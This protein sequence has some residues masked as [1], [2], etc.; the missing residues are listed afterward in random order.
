MNFEVNKK[1]CSKCA[2][3]VKDCVCAVLEMGDDAFPKVREGKENSCV[4]CQHCFAICPTGAVSIFGKNPDKSLI[5]TEEVSSQ[6]LVALVKNRR[7][8]R[9]FER[10]TISKKKLNTILDALSWTPTGCNA[11]SLH[12]T[13]IDDIDVMDKFR[14]DVVSK[15]IT[16]IESKKIPK[17][18]SEG[19]KFAEPVLLAGVDLIFRTAPQIIFVSTP[20]NAPTGNNDCI[21][22]LS[23]FEM[24]A[25]SMKIGTTWCGYIV[26]IL[27]NIL[28]EMYK[29]LE[30]PEGNIIHGAMLFG[31][32]AVS[33]CRATQPTAISI[34]SV[35]SKATD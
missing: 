13:I 24:I 5:L 14:A 26:T 1:R 29:A 15:L 31:P 33:Y 16:L 2:A 30:I 8:C 12:V 35:G 7:S 22:A 23:Q 17:R 9:N 27:N 21:I 20:K 25:Q 11:H 28:P 10:K 6:A 18:F 3:C 4:G 34:N 19:F 32:P